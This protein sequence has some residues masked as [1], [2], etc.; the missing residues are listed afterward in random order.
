MGSLVQLKRRYP[1]LPSHN[2]S[3]RAEARESTKS[4][5]VLISVFSATALIMGAAVVAAASS[6]WADVGLISL[7]ILVFAL[8]KIALANALFY[9]MIKSDKADEARAKSTTGAVFR[10]PAYRRNPPRP[11][12]R[13]M[14]GQTVVKLAALAKHKSPRAPRPR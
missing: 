11:L 10:L 5:V 14:P 2:L 7:F 6:T 13:R 8:V 12:G 4:I 3:E 1:A 9:V